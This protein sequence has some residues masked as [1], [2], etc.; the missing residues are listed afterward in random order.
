MLAAVENHSCLDVG[1]TK[2][3]A[4]FLPKGPVL[5]GQFLLN[6]S[7]MIKALTLLDPS[8]FITALRET[9]AE[10]AYL[11]KQGDFKNSLDIE[12]VTY[13]SFPI[14][15]LDHQTGFSDLTEQFVLCF[16]SNCIFA[17]SVVAL[18]QLIDALEEGYGFKVR[19]E[20]LNSLRGSG[21]PTDYNT[22]LAALLAIHR[23][24]I[25][26]KG[27]LPPTQVFEL[28]LKAL[29]I[30]GLTNNTRV[31]AKHAFEWLNAKWPFIWEHQQFLLKYPAFYEKSID[32]V[33]IAEG[34]SW[35]D[36]LIDLLQA[37]LPTMGLN[38]ESQLNSILN[39]IRKKR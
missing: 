7:K 37:I 36:K 8:L 19:K 5:E 34:D 23:L 17:E 4:T 22:S 16:V 27:T 12:S 21:P 15:T 24:A 10:F 6:P 14:P 29:Q 30:A 35:V 31:M 11:K 39:D 9:I 20:L 38:N 25:D 1:I 33:R 3:L 28:A 2:N 18:D 13:G 26:K 32:Q